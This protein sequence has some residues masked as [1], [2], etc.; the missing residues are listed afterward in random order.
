MDFRSCMEIVAHLWLPVLAGAAAVWIASAIVWMALPH[1]RKDWKKLPDEAAF[2]SA[3]RAMN[4]PPGQYGYPHF[5]SHA[6]AQK[7]EMQKLWKEGPMGML[8]VWTSN[9]S[10][11]RNMFITFLV[12]LV[13]SAMIGYLGVITVPPGSGFG[14][15]F[16]VLGTAGVLAYSFAFIPNGVW[17]QQGRSTVM[18][19]IDGIAYGLIIGAV[20]AALW[21]SAAA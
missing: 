10:M 8:S 14:R 6:E 5:G 13:V 17:F 9:I 20:M 4:I 11:G 15:A 1:H 3:V 7:P 16:Q 21:P 12:H 2:M 18:N 19:V